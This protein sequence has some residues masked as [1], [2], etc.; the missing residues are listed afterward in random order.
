M[1][2]TLDSPAPSPALSPAALLAALRLQVEWGA[3]E[4]LA[5]LPLDRREQP[6]V[7]AARPQVLP[8]RPSAPAAPAPAVLASLDAM[9]ME[10]LLAAWSASDGGGL[11]ATSSNSVL[12]AGDPGAALLLIGEAPD[13]EDDMAGTAFAGATGHYLD[14]MLASAGLDRSMLRLAF[15]TPWRP[16]GGRSP[17]E[18]ELRA[19][20]PF[21]H[22]YLS[23]A[24]PDRLV[25]FGNAAVKALTGNLDGV[26]KSR[27]RWRDA[28]IP[29]HGAPVPALAMHPPGQVRRKPALRKDAWVDLLLLR[30]ALDG[31]V[32]RLD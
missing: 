22:R 28:R 31:T 3:D 7:P 14:R 20:L 27:G 32:E 4:A 26:R 16:P 23:L 29:G 18:F 15:L 12:P 17:Y 30:Q 1:G 11:R 24:P 21:L 10:E 5:P 8:Q 6:A 13:A 19:S 9:G 25:L 2:E